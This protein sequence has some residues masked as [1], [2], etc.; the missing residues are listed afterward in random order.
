MSIGKEGKHGTHRKL[1]RYACKTHILP[2]D[3]QSKTQETGK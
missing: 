3:N 1:E 2:H